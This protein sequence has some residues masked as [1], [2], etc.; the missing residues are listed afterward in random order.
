MPFILNSFHFF[1]LLKGHFPAFQTIC[2][3]KTLIKH[4]SSGKEFKDRNLPLWRR[5]HIHRCAL[6]GSLAP[7]A[8]GTR[9]CPA[10]TQYDL[11]VNDPEQYAGFSTSKFR[12]SLHD[13]KVTM[14]AVDSAEDI[15]KSINAELENLRKWLHGNNKLQTTS[16]IIGTNRKLHQSNCREL[17]QANFKISGEVVDHI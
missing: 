14:N 7:P 13:L 4:C 2:F 10:F 16:M 3:K 5:I 9:R 6:T 15:T 8:L 11:I 17:I 12:L 1:Y